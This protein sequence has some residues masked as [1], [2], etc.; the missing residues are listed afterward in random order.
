MG[1][2][3]VYFLIFPGLFFSGIIGGLISWADRKITARVQFRQGPPIFQPLYDF[4]KLLSKETIIPLHGSV[5]TYI[6]APV[7]ALFGATISAVFILLPVLGLETGFAGDIIV[8]IYLLNIPSFAYIIGALASGNPLA[9]VGASREMKLI[10]SYEMPFLLVLISIIIKSGMTII[11][12][13]I[14]GYQTANGAFIGS[15]SGIIGFITVMMCIQAKMGLVPFD[16]AEGEGE[17]C[18]GITIEFSGSILAFFKLTRYIMFFALPALVAG[19]FFAGLSLSG[20][21]ILWSILK[22]FVIVLLITLIRNTNPRVRIDQA[23]RFFW[24]WM[25]LFAIISIVLA[26]MGI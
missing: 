18:D 19:L 4:V 1:I 3:I 26:L 5:T 6:L 12:S 25:N 7:F 23:M 13:E 17:I 15:L 8:I 21:H 24:L 10:L 14:I 11:L 9:A 22:V 2:E 20:I 16:M